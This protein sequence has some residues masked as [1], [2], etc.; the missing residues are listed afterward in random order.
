[1]APKKK[2]K[3]KSTARKTAARTKKKATKRA[4]RK[5]KSSAKTSAKSKT[6]EAGAECHDI[7]ETIE[8]RTKKVPRKS[9]AIDDGAIR[10]QPGLDVPKP[11]EL[12]RA[13]DIDARKAKK[14]HEEIEALARWIRADKKRS[15]E[16]EEAP[17]RVLAQRD[18]K[19]ASQIQLLHPKLIE[20][21]LGLVVPCCDDLPPASEYADCVRNI[22]KLVA[23][24]MQRNSANRS[25]FK[26]DTDAAVDAAAPFAPDI[27]KMLA[28]QALRTASA[29][30]GGAA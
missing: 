4:S 1:M 24:W 26:S 3:K 22:L 7:G 15:A 13:L 25:V 14:L 29:I 23:Q 11:A 9:Q 20:V 17:V 5:T 30:Q 21:L 19:I 8:V 18:P 27:G 28:K 6:H 10:T 16:F 12:A 2:T